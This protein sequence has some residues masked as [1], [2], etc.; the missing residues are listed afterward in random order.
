MVKPTQDNV[1]S[2]EESKGLLPRRNLSQKWQNIIQFSRDIFIPLPKV[3]HFFLKKFVLRVSTSPVF[4]N[5]MDPSQ[6]IPGLLM[7][8]TSPLSHPCQGQIKTC[9]MRLCISKLHSKSPFNPPSTPKPL[10]L[11]NRSV[12]LWM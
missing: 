8:Q 4:Y 7:M 6:E 3:Q 12:S 5:L 1:V 2:W 10:S 11:V 9:P